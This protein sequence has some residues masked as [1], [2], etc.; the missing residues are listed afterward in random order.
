[1]LNG[2]KIP[3]KIGDKVMMNVC[4]WRRFFDDAWIPV[5]ILGITEMTDTIRIDFEAFFDKE[6]ALDPEVKKEP[7]S[8]VLLTGN[9]FVD[10][11]TEVNARL[12]PMICML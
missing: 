2:I 3:L 9:L 12:R 10:N 6:Y 1:M 11:Q 4:D 7:T 8:C 5:K